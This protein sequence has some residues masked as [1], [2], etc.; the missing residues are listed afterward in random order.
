MTKRVRVCAIK[1]DGGRAEVKC[2]WLSLFLRF[3]N[4]YIY[5]LVGWEMGKGG[6]L[7]KRGKREG[8]GWG[9]KGGSFKNRDEYGYHVPKISD[10]S[11]ISCSVF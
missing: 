6:G 2:R 11:R 4:K 10:A 5:V 9:I 1:E 8:G 7:A 3:F